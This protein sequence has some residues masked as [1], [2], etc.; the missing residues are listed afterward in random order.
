MEEQVLKQKLE[1]ALNLKVQ[2]E[3]AKDTLSEAV[4]ASC[5]ELDMPKAL[6]NHYLKLAYLK[7][8]K[9]EGW[10][11]ELEKADGVERIEGLF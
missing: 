2:L 8:Y 5:E 4:D 7:T 9:P 1:N 11:K 6:F 10:E 3:G